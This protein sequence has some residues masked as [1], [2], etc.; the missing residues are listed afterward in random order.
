MLRK[1][2][3]ELFNKRVWHK[4]WKLPPWDWWIGRDRTYAHWLKVPLVAHT[5]NWLWPYGLARLVGI[6]SWPAWFVAVVA[7]FAGQLQAFDKLN[8]GTEIGY[9]V[10]NVLWR[11]VI[12]GVVGSAILLVGSIIP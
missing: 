7:V 9:D 2:Y 1:L 8:K 11:T 4:W 3:P 10:R 5:I 12:A 6:D